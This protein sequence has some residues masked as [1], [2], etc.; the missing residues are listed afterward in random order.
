MGT[1][2]EQLLIA[3]A[4]RGDDVAYE[5]L[6]APLVEPA[7]KLA[8]G[9]VHDTHLAEDVVQE[10]AVR[11]WR[12]LK[13]LRDGTSIRPWFL[14]IVANQCREMRRGHWSRLI[15]RRDVTRPVNDSNEAAIARMELRSLLE[16]L[17]KQERLVIVLRFYLDL[18]WS[19]VA[20]ITG[21]GEAGARSRFYRALGKLRPK[22]HAVVTT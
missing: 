16:Q 2:R 14:E 20:A 6:L 1:E 8:C 17:G 19:D 11:A 21:L 12:K 13:N 4:K 18:P 15:L 10:A 22:D 7:H 3:R 9:L 5:Q